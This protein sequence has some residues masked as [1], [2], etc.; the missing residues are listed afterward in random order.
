[1][2]HLAHLRLVER[3]EKPA[4]GVAVALRQVAA[5]RASSEP[6]D[7]RASLVELAAAALAWARVTDPPAD[8]PFD[9]SEHQRG[10]APDGLEQA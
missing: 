7:L 3:R 5:A 10:P 9:A 8:A 1:M 6:G 4:A 2:L